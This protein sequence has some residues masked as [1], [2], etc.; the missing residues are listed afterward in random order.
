[1][2]IIITKHARLLRLEC[3]KLRWSSLVLD[4]GT[5]ERRDRPQG[6]CVL[7]GRSSEFKTRWAGVWW[8]P[9]LASAYL[10]RALLIN[11]KSDRYSQPMMRGE[12][13]LKCLD[14]S[15]LNNVHLT[16]AWHRGLSVD[17]YTLAGSSS[18]TL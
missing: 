10:S 13:T 17:H 3:M 6:R 12:D 14:T 5:A 18:C 11:T 9:F 8:P 15:A 2:I 16:C 4:N 1:M 7:M